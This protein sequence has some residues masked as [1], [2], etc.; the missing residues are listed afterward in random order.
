MLDR[1]LIGSNL[2]GLGKEGDADGLGLG[3]SDFLIQGWGWTRATFFGG[4]PEAAE[5]LGNLFML[6]WGTDAEIQEKKSFYLS[7]SLVVVL[8][9]MPE[10]M[11]ID[12]YWV[13]ITNRPHWK[14]V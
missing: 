8:V 3:V 13:W 9:K 4:G 5:G 2:A 12:V 7:Q 11:D 6:V 14:L 10:C 1:A